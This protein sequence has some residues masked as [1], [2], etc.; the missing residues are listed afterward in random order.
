MA[1]VS[2]HYDVEGGIRELQHARDTREASFREMAAIMAR[3]AG[4]AAADRWPD[5]KAREQA[6]IGCV[7]AAATMAEYAHH[8]PAATM[9]NC[10]G[11][12]GLALVESARAEAE[13][14]VRGETR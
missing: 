9:L 5:P 7:V 14:S 11:L 13:R 3:A 4:N 10:V 6:G 2:V 8:A 12:L 1:E